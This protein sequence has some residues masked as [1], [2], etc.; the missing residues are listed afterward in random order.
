MSGMNK[1]YLIIAAVVAVAAVAAIVWYTLSRSGED[2]LENYTDNYVMLDLYGPPDWLAA[3]SH[4]AVWKN[5]TYTLPMA[6]KIVEP[7]P[8]N[9]PLLGVVKSKD[10]R[11]LVTV[12][13]CPVDIASLSLSDLSVMISDSVLLNDVNGRS[14]SVVIKAFAPAGTD[15]ESYQRPDDN[16]L[17]AILAPSRVYSLTQKDWLQAQD[18]RN[19]DLDIP[20]EPRE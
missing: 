16:T 3:H 10:G 4:T 15:R 17:R 2:T 9:E 19:N 12:A 18:S 20:D 13:G 14:A 6:F 8:T 1:K 11:K 7:S 5:K